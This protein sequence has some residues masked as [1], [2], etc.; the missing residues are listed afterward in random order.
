MLANMV[1]ADDQGGAATLVHFTLGLAE[2]TITF[3]L[4]S[5]P[6]NRH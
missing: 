5:P 2:E 1:T 6:T 4:L 3:T